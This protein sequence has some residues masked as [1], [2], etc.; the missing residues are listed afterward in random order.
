MATN[1]HSKIILQKHL[2][3]ML[4]N[5][6]PGF[7]VGLDNDDNIYLWNV[8]IVG[9]PDTL[10]EGGFFKAQLQFPTEYPM[11]PPKMKFLCEM[12][13]PNVSKDGDVCISILHEPGEDS[14]GYEKAS[15]RWLP[16]HSVESIL[17]SVISLLADPNTE[18]PANVDAAVRNINLR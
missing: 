14:Y 5:P 2:K 6:E 13:H 12:W 4:K 16:V 10:Y 11:K 9:P 18:S 1:P 17:H 3:E 15:E 7:S 8:M